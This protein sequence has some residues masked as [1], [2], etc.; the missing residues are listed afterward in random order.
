MWLSLDNKKST[1][2]FGIIQ[3]IFGLILS[4]IKQR[5]LSFYLAEIQAG[6]IEWTYIFY[7]LPYLFTGILIIIGGIIIIVIGFF[8]FNREAQ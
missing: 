7:A 4:F 6:S 3:I 2:S 1:I 8:Y 5:D